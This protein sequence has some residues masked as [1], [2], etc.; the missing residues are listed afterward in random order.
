[1]QIRAVIAA[2]VGA[3]GASGT[4]LGDLTFVAQSR[5]ISVTTMADGQTSEQAANDF[6]P[7]VATVSRN[8]PAVVEGVQGINAGTTDISCHFDREI[9]AATVRMFAQGVVGQTTQVNAMTT[10]LVDV[11]FDNTQASPFRLVLTGTDIAAL[12][13]NEVRV[14]LTSSD[15]GTVYFEQQASNLGTNFLGQL[16]AGRMR[17]EF[18]AAQTSDLGE[19]GRE[20]E[21][22]LTVPA[23]PCDADFDDGSFTG[24]PD[25]GVTVD[26]LLYYVHVFGLGDRDADVDDG[27]GRGHRDQAVTIED[28]LYYLAHFESGC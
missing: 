25:Y 15:D 21:V 27:S 11:T 24:T 14:R 9:V 20:Y 5:S 6:A 26:D 28:L 3:V 18:L 19:C 13:V 2:T 22:E 16:P 4:C 7:F 1:M 8:V 12:G 10:T 17:F 23:R